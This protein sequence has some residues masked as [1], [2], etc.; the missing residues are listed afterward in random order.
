MK[1]RNRII[2]CIALLL[3]CYS[4]LLAQERQLAQQEIRALLQTA[5]QMEAQGRLEQAGELFS[6][7]AK[8]QAPQ[9][10]LNSYSSARHCFERIKAL[11]AW[12]SLIQE[13]QKNYR[14]L[15]F[16]ADLAE[17][18]FLRGDKP[19]A[20]RQWRQIVE[21]NPQD[22]QAY[23]LTGSALITNQLFEEAQWCYER[24]R[25]EFKDQGKF[26]FELALVYQAQS[27]FGKM[28]DEYLAFLQKNPA[29]LGYIQT[30]LLSAAVEPEA[31]QEITES[32]ERA[33]KSV[34]SFKLQG[35]QLLAGLYTQ[36]RQYAKALRC[37]D[38]LEE[39]ARE[40][41][42]S[43]QGQYYYAFANVAM[44]DGALAEAR[45]ALEALTK[46]ATMKS[47][48]RVHAAF[49]L[50]Q[51]LEKEAAYDQ[52]VAAYESF[53]KSYG[54]WPE[55]PALYLR[56]GTLYF[57]HFFNL[58][59]AD[60]AFRRMLNRPQ[61]PIAF[62][63]I[64]YQKRAEC[65]IARGDLKKA[66]DFLQRLKREIPQPF[67]QA[68]QADLML[69]RINLY[70]GRPLLAFHKLANLINGQELRTE[71]K[72]DTAQNDILELY[73]L[74]REN[75]QDSLGLALFGRGQW[76]E[77]QHNYAAALDTL[78]RILQ[79][80]KN[81]ALREQVL[82]G[83]IALLRK[84]RRPAEALEIC[85]SLSADSTGLTPDLA[86]LTMADVHE[87]MAQ[88]QKALHLL[89]TFLEKYPESIYIEQARGRIRILEMRYP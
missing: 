18:A 23:M 33:Q 10:D 5:Q 57:D 36:S 2:L 22:E 38:Y 53:I 21:S 9:R 43:E 52:A 68:R 76:L 73:L 34:A 87:E 20:I 50:A 64:G 72:A 45:L 80:S 25:K 79:I 28:T 47:P 17:I 88:P 49:A 48:Y 60:S 54:D 44:D 85:A 30:Q 65:A 24:G 66:E 82:Y 4:A 26:F 69:A 39:N 74:L 89:E 37:Y 8:A 70:E 62:R 19:A 41:D 81:S 42:P 27:D 35:C 75:Q 16:E 32:I 46:H 83:Q 51:L 3:L 55:I 58:A 84:L 29:Q 67:S 13:L 61:L 63:L 56:L 71:A 40:K 78:G 31:I 11:D 1:S 86:L 59:A 12:E 15:R 6:R 77:Q 14:S 7:V